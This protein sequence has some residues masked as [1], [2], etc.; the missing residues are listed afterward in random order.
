MAKRSARRSLLYI[1]GSSQK[2]L[3]KIGT[4]TS[5]AVL[6]DLEDAV[7]LEEKDN[8]RSNV[9]EALQAWA[10]CGRELICRINAADTI[11]CYEDI[12]AVTG[13]PLSA[14]I[15]PK[16]NERFLIAV[17]LMLTAAEQK[18]GLAPGSIEMIPLF[19]TAY[20]IA[21]AYQVLGASARI[22]AVQLG[23]EDLTKEQGID[24]TREGREFL[25]AR[26]QLAMAA[27]ARELDILDTPYPD[28][29]DLEG[30]EA[31]ARL[32]K[33]LGFTGKTCIHPSHIETINRVFSPAA[34]E[35]DF[36]RGVVEAYAVSVAEGRGACMYNGKM[37]DKPVAERAEKLLKKAKALRLITE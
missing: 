20:A 9:A 36:A 11:W 22:T 23:A 21:N 3:G 17:D 14:V 4:V 5:D 37:I 24:R 10:G 12:L 18:K 28:I 16:A 30:L 29:R 7:S 32:V 34:G 6:M 1:P 27:R 25:F 31:D 8:A 15:V 13:E 33:S 2:M 26:Q 19:E 35:I